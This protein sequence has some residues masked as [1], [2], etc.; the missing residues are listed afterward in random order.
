MYSQ[1]PEDREVS[2]AKPDH[3]VEQVIWMGIGTDG[4]APSTIGPCDTPVSVA[5]FRIDLPSPGT[6]DHF[7]VMKG[8]GV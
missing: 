3:I 2:D 5:G 1:S 6:M 7:P 4:H 8:D